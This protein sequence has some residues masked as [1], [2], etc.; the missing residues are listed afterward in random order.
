MA[1]IGIA[2][3]ISAG[4]G[5]LGAMSSGGGSGP[6]Q[7]NTKE[8]WAEAAP[9]LKQQIADGQALQQ[10]YA[11]NPFSP[12]QQTAYNNTFS[13][14]NH[15]RSN[16]APGL[17][18]FANNMM[19]GPGYQRRQLERPGQGG[20]GPHPP[21]QQPQQQQP[22]GLMQ[23]PFGMAQGGLMGNQYAPPDFSTPSA[24]P[25]AEAPQT[26][27]MTPDMAD[28]FMRRLEQQQLDRVRHPND[29]GGA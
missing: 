15:F 8:P 4:T 20:Y 28:E 7:T 27:V 12:Q 16:T 25:R 22:G 13:D 11:A 6:A 1:V 24:P 26:G 10:R 19:I 9:W 17:M 14:L 18:N 23:G 21:L 3:L 2:G 29:G 5:L